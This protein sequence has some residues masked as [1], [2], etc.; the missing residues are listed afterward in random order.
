MPEKADTSDAIFPP[1]FLN[2]AVATT[3]AEAGPPTAS[4]QW[5]GPQ[6]KTRWRGLFLGVRMAG[7][8][9]GSLHLRVALF[10]HGARLQ[11]KRKGQNLTELVSFVKFSESRQARRNK[12][13]NYRPSRVPV[14]ESPKRMR[15]P[16]ASVPCQ[17]E[18]IERL[19][20]DLLK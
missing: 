7:Y 15:T 13:R 14:Y 19:K 4:D 10:P 2:Y 20:P 18:G 9:N 1:P 12:P 17:S 8:Q 3:G 11:A 16:L 5:A 6:K